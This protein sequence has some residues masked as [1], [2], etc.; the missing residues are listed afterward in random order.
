MHSRIAELEQEVTKYRE[1]LGKAK[2]LNDAMWEGLVQKVLN[3]D[4]ET[5]SDTD[6]EPRSKKNKIVK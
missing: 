4:D 5:Q 6:K 3:L 2:G 1:L